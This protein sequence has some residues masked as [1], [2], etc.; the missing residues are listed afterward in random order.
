M[1][2][3]PE[4]VGNFL[5]VFD[6]VKEKII[7]QEGCLRLELL[8]EI[9]EGSTLFT[10]SYWEAEADLDRYR[11]SELFGVT[12]KKTKALFSHPAEAW[13]TQKLHLLD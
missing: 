5:E 13:S 12:W 10:Y 6:S 4:E 9:Q 2:F 8:Q 7:A 1:Q 3:R 11:H